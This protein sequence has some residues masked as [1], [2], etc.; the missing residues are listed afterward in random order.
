MDKEYFLFCRKRR[1]PGNIGPKLLTIINLELKQ[2]CVPL[3]N[4]TVLSCDLQILSSTHQ[5]KL[6]TFRPST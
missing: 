1:Q 3:N 4:V 2:Q 5:S 6:S